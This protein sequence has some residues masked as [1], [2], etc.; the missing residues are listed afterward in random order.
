MEAVG[1]EVKRGSGYNNAVRE[2]RM[3]IGRA[4]KG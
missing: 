3:G 1:P 2:S 4:V